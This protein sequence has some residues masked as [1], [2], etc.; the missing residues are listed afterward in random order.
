MAKK[1]EKVEKE[2]IVQAETRFSKEQILKS[3]KYREHIDLVGALLDGK[4]S[5]SLKEVDEQIK[6][7]KKREVKIC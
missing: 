6:Q 7:F 5:Y 2:P 1:V 4:K 3:E